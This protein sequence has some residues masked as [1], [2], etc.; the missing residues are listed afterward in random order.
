MPLEIKD[1]QEPSWA[2]VIYSCGNK[3]SQPA[4]FGGPDAWTICEG[5]R[6]SGPVLKALQH[7]LLYMRHADEAYKVTSITNFY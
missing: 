2:K 7:K 3:I 5:M 4:F 6:W 1:L